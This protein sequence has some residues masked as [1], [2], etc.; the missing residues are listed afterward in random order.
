MKEKKLISVHIRPATA[1]L[2]FQLA[3]ETRLTRIEILRLA[4]EQ[5]AAAKKPAQVEAGQKPL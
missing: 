2:L 1:E 4:V 3:Y 5:F